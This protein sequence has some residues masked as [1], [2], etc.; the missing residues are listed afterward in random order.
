[1]PENDHGLEISQCSGTES[2]SDWRG[3][4]RTED[5]KLMAFNRI[6]PTAPLFCTGLTCSI[7][8]RRP[9]SRLAHTPGYFVYGSVCAGAGGHLAL[10]V[11]SHHTD[12]VVS[13]GAGPGGD[14]VLCCRRPAR[15]VRAAALCRVRRHVL[16]AE[17]GLS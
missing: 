4:L 9:P 16:W 11:D 7:S 10:A 17:R 6:L 3:I 2:M 12:G 15:T 5:I 14:R 1:M 13:L 8:K